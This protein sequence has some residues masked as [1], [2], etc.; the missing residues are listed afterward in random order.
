MP[1]HEIPLHVVSVTGIVVRD[2]GMILATR[3]ED[4]G[5]WVPPGGI[6][7]WGEGFEEGV[8]REVL[9][10]TG[11]TVSPIRVT[12]IYKNLDRFTISIAF[13]CS[14]RSYGEH[15]SDETADMG[16]FTVYDSQAMM[17]PIRAIRVTDAL[18]NG[19]LVVRSYR[20]TQADFD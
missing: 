7:E 3:R 10:E 18:R 15:S 16:W 2:D 14:V 13:L 1:N 11:V 19:G 4:D 17:P 8:I 5:S 20:N 12:G 9:E 6:L